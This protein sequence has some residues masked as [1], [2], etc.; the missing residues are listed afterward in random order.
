MVWNSLIPISGILCE[1]Q[2]IQVACPIS[3]QHI[4]TYSTA[5]WSVCIHL[6]LLFTLRN[7]YVSFNSLMSQLGTTMKFVSAVTQNLLLWQWCSGI[8]ANVRDAQTTWQ[9]W[10][11]IWDFQRV[12]LQLFS[13]SQGAGP[14]HWGNTRCLW[15]Q[16]I[17]ALS[18]E[19]A[20]AGLSTPW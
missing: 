13:F 18:A 12:K 20:K 16:V 4:N 5:S 9:W 14:K 15:Q 2:M 7:S 10:V 3:R 6:L 19:R 1:S 11:S 17:K 8:S